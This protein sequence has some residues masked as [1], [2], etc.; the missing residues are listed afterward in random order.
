MA[1]YYNQEVKIKGRVIDVSL[2]YG[3]YNGARVVK[4][5]PLT[6]DKKIE[7]KILRLLERPHMQ[8]E[9]EKLEEMI[10]SSY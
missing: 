2:R 10:H 4:G 1:W 3:C 6:I 5:K 9:R 8:A 7:T